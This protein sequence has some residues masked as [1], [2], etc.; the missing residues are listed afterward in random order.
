MWKPVASHTHV[1]HRA[2]CVHTNISN[3]GGTYMT[4]PRINGFWVRTDTICI[5]TE[6][7]E[8]LE[9]EMSFACVVTMD[10]L[11][12]IVGGRRKVHARV[13]VR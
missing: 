8:Y 10:I 11:W 2:L 7:H 3:L 6:P 1:R 12:L 9:Y 13:E 5:D 4:N